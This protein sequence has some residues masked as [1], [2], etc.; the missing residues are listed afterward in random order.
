MSLKAVVVL[1]GEGNTKGTVHFEQN[2]SVDAI[3]C[4]IRLLFWPVLFF[5]FNLITD[6]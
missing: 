3:Q 6:G 5:N 2:V 4:L 1:T